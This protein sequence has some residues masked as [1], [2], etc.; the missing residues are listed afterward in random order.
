MREMLLA[1]L[2]CLCGTLG[3]MS[4][5]LAPRKGGNVV[6]VFPPNT[7]PT[8]AF[9]A[10]RASGLTVLDFPRAHIVLAAPNGNQALERPIGSWLMIDA[11]GAGGCSRNDQRTKGRKA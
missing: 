4:V 9:L 5:A 10:V 7:T 3:V 8:G 11:M 6:V 1:A 2:F